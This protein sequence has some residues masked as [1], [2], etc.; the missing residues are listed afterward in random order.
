[1]KKLRAEEGGEEDV[2]L[3][4][5]DEAPPPGRR[6]GHVT[7]GS[8]GKVYYPKKVDGRRKDAGRGKSYRAA[9][10]P[11]S[12]NYLARFGKV[13][14]AMVDLILSPKGYLEEQAN[15]L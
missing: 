8:K 1:M 13:K 3:A 4:S 5:P 7:K 9:M 6:E 14:L 11:A 10:G 15:Y 12:W 2:L